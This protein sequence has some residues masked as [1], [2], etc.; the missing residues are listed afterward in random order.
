MW[1]L[2]ISFGYLAD[3]ESEI[4]SI[5]TIPQLVVFID[6]LPLERPMEDYS[7]HF[8]RLSKA[9]TTEPRIKLKTWIN[10]QLKRL[11]L[12]VL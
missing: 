12:V 10:L 2:G 5:K 11:W 6:V 1:Q 8:I 9:K 7:V 3:R 4:V